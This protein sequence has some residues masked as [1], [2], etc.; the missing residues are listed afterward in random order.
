MMF[1]CLFGDF[2]LFLMIRRPPRSTRTDTLCPYTTL[3]R[4]LK[5]Q[6]AFTRGIGQSLHPPVKEVTTAVEDDF[7]DAG[8]HRAL[9]HQ[10]ADL[11]GRGLVGAALQL[12]LQRAVDAGRPH[13]GLARAVVHDLRVTVLAGAAHRQATP[14][15]RWKST[16]MNPRPLCP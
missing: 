1:C 16:P 7:L 14:A 12:V 8:R 13:Q 6:T 2:F 4:S 5:R 11:R 15:A 10:L 9:G 3:F